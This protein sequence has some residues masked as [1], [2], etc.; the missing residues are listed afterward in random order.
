MSGRW[1]ERGEGGNGNACATFVSPSFK[2]ILEASLE[3]V[4]N[5]ALGTITQTMSFTI[6]ATRNNAEVVVILV[7]LLLLWLLRRTV[8]LWMTILHTLA[9]EHDCPS[10]T[11]VLSSGWRPQHVRIHD[12]QFSFSVTK[13][14]EA[15]VER[16]V[17]VLKHGIH[18]SSLLQEE[19][20]MS[21]FRPT[22]CMKS[23]N[24]CKLR[25]LTN[26]YPYFIWSTRIVVHSSYM[27]VCRQKHIDQHHC[28]SF[29]V[30]IEIAPEP[31]LSH[32]PYDKY[33]HF[34]PKMIT[35]PIVRGLAV[36]NGSFRAV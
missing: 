26:K 32:G 12:V 30:V 29:K 28:T 5:D 22:G 24:S 11:D 17:V 35:Y 13:G 34:S 2:W 14:V 1:A 23:V 9:L 3:A 8:T 15:D 27:Y 6:T 19:T 4:H 25:S 21:I 10:D 18:M 7:L 33:Q 31:S 16:V 36:S 20:G